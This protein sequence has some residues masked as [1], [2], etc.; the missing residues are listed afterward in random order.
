MT[1]RDTDA[2]TLAN[3]EKDGIM[4]PFR[5][6]D[7]LYKATQCQWLNMDSSTGIVTILKTRRDFLK[8]YVF[9]GVYR[10]EAAQN[11]GYVK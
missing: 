6:Q 10:R 9:D 1:Y 5:D 11:T 3:Q 2:Y 4:S 8:T 7:V